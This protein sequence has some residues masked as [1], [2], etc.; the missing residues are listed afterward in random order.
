MHRPPN[1]VDVFLP[2]KAI[3]QQKNSYLRKTT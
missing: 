1:E 3:Y 2:K